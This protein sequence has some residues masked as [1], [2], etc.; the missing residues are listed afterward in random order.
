M[1]YHN[2]LRAISGT[3]LAIERRKL[4]Q[5]VAFLEI[6]AAGLEVSEEARAEFRAAQQTARK[7]RIGNGVGVLPIVGSISHRLT[8]MQEMSGGVSIQELTRDFRAMVNRPD[9]GTIVLDMDSPGGVVDGVPEF[10]DEIFAAR[11]QKRII[12]VA[13]TM[14]A[15]AGYWIMSAASEAVVTPS[16]S[17]GSLGVYALHL[18]ESAALEMEGLRPTYISAGKFK[19]EGNPAAPLS[20]EARG[21]IQADVDA[22]YSMFVRAVSKGRGIAATVVRDGFGQGRLV[23]AKDAKAMGMVDRIDTLQGVLTR[24][25]V[26]SGNADARLGVMSEHNIMMLRVGAADYSDNVTDEDMDRIKRVSP[27]DA[28]GVSVEGNIIRPAVA[29]STGIDISDK[30]IETDSEKPDEPEAPA[31]NP[32]H[33]RLALLK[34]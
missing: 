33:R 21:A 6:K 16:G 17:V 7:P 23:L 18:D 20:D 2:I 1:K 27:Q 30:G 26:G 19:V 9:V 31:R 10:T 24:L 22:F 11:S 29:E 32:R 13:N 15:S 25:G 12:A 3:P 34:A 4:D 28:S 14:A 5:I 8:G